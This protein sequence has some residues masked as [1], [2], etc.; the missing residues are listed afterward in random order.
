M[1]KGLRNTI[2]AVG[3]LACAGTIGLSAAQRGGGQNAAQPSA[4]RNFTAIGCLSREGSAG[5]RGGAA[6]TFIITDTRANPPAKYRLDGTAD[7]LGWH[8]GHT[9]EVTG[10][11]T[12]AAAGAMATL[13]V[14]SLV[15]I[16]TTCASS[17]K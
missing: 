14:Q 11:L 4:P 16:S 1:S 7:Q 12:P 15:Y 10:P 6:P 3:A 5:G 8:V 9:L 13:K 17:S 2:A